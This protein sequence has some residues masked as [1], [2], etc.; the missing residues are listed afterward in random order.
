MTVATEGNINRAMEEK[1]AQKIL[2]KN[3]AYSLYA[4]LLLLSPVLIV[5]WGKQDIA[6]LFPVFYGVFIGLLV[7]WSIGLLVY[8]SIGLLVYW[9]IG[10]LVNGALAKSGKYR[11]EYNQLGRGQV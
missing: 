5:A 7:Y 10:L 8:W 11:D 4:I 6:V 3:L 9:S 2:L 1:R